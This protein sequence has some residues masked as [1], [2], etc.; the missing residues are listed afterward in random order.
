MNKIKPLNRRKFLLGVSAAVAG[1]AVFGSRQTAASPGE[2]AGNQGKEKMKI[3]VLTGSP[4][5]NGNSN[6]LASEFIRGATEKGHDVFRFDTAQ[7]NV[8]PCIACNSCGMDGPC[9]F[10]DDFEQ[11][12]EHIVPA[13]AVVFA[14]P[15]Y[16]FGISSQLKTVI[17]R[18]YAL[19]GQI[20]VP[21]KGA[22]LMTYA[23]TSPKQAIPIDSHYD[24]LMDYLGWE[25][26]G[27]IIA[28]GVW[29]AGSIK[30][31]KYPEMAYNLGR[32][33]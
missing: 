29:P 32:S 17:D 28:P 15:M 23:N 4:R 31:T 21:K 1:I 13:D 16:Y 9:V 8:H 19:N 12:R 5:K 11:V 30:S 24:T 18:F 33:I 14:T 10:K 2:F 6:G 26:A 27:K 7:S 25:N 20:H 3:L 22:L